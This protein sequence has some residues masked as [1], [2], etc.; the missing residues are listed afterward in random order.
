M[1]AAEMIGAEAV[2]QVP[3]ALGLMDREAASAAAGCADRYY[4]HYKLHDFSNAR[5]QE[6][7]ELL[8]LA[9]LYRH[10]SNSF[11]GKEKIRVWALSA[12]RFWEKLRR[13]DGSF[14]EVYPFERSF[15]ATA[16]ST[17]H[18]SESLILLG[19]KPS[20]DLIP[21]GRWLA[22]HDAPDVTN[23]RAAAAASLANLSLLL[24]HDAFLSVAR[25]RAAKIR[26][27]CERRGYFN[28]YGGGDTGYASITLSALALYADR[29]KDA[30]AAAWI[31]K[32]AEDMGGRLDES[33]RFAYEGQSRATRF[34]YP[35]ALAWSNSRH[36]EKIARGAAEEKILKPSWMDD[37]YAMPFAADYLR[38]AARAR[39]GA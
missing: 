22:C 6:I 38:A 3:R 17:L 19:E 21:V 35:Y 28:E 1:D 32:R 15:C 27:D 26:E 31:K 16:F 36:L 37:R 5:A 18:A 12:V 20:V 23:Q 10:P 24:G 30:E 13:C 2:R 11:F 25:A 4:W 8:A 34:F 33:G 39:G 14:D 9:F 29:A 7:S